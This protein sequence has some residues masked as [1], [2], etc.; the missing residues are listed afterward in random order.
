MK[1]VDNSSQGDGPGDGPKGKH[2]G[3]RGRSPRNSAP[4]TLSGIDR[5]APRHADYTMHHWQENLTKILALK[6]ANLRG[7]D[8]MDKM[9]YFG[10]IQFA[11]GRNAGISRLKL[12]AGPTYPPVEYAS[13]ENIEDMV[14]SLHFEGLGK[15]IEATSPAARLLKGVFDEAVVLSTDHGRAQQFI[16]SHF[17]ARQ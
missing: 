8:V 15:T 9:N 3:K 12:E 14:S 10:N 13:L 6:L 1:P 17:H 7:V 11:L 2:E 4:L 5:L 16:N